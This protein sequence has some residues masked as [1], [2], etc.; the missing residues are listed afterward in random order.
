MPESVWMDWDP[1][2]ELQPPQ[3]LIPAD[4]RRRLKA[5]LVLG[6]V[7]GTVSLLHWVESGHWLV[8]G[9]AFLM[10]GHVLRLSVG[11]PL[12][13]PDLLELE[14]EAGVGDPLPA[15]VRLPQVS[16]LIPAK[17]ES[18]VL[19]RLLES[20]NQLDYPTQ[21]LD[22]WVIDDGSSDDSFAIVSRYQSQMPHLRLHQRPPGSQGGKSGALNEVWPQ[23]AGEII[24]VCDADA[25][26]PNNFL[27]QALPSFRVSAHAKRPV[28][29]VQVQKAISNAEQNFWTRQQRAEMA[30]DSYIQ[31]QRIAIGGIG[32]LRGNGQLVRRDVLKK[33]GGWNE[34]TVTDDLDLTFKL[35]LAGIDIAFVVDVAVQEEGVTHWQALWHQRSRWAEGGYQRYL[36]YGLRLLHHLSPG[37]SVDLLLFFISQYL[38]PM[39][40]I[41]D[42]AWNLFYSHHSVLAPIGIVMAATVIGGFTAG[43]SQI[44]Q[45]RGWRLIR[46]LSLGLLYMLHW[47]PVMIVTTS[48]MCIQPK[49]LKWV[50]T[51]HQGSP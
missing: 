34:A 23:T 46:D 40:L 24:L 45:R 28:G 31:R 13:Q 12:P 51:V 7:W 8:W 33:C 1:L 14:R 49:R 6:L 5:L 26:L 38:M 10:A 29:A 22:I 36:D 42:L 11:Q 21:H 50:K 4:Q 20:L 30:Y 47:I 19:P 2:D 25:Q 15:A 9:L 43:L 37:K 17:N 48:R 39:A 27:R 16:I 35:H 44:H 3:W 32:E 18:A 41:P